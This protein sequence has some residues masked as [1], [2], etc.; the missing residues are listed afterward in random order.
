MSFRCQPLARGETVELVMH[1][2]IGRGEV[3]SAAV[4]R[5]LMQFPN[6]RELRVYL[7]SPGGDAFGGQAI[8]AALNRHPARVRV[9]VD[10]LAASAA[11]LVAMAGDDIRMA[12]GAMLM[13]HDPWTIAAGSAA[14]MRQIAEDLDRV[15]LSMRDIYAA[16]SG[17]DKDEIEEWM[18][19]E[20]WF[21]AAEA[22]S[23]G[24]ATQMLPAK[25]AAACV[26]PSD[27]RAMFRRL[28]SALAAPRHETSARPGPVVAEWEKR[29]A[30]TE[31]R[32][33]AEKARRIAGK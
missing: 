32:I 29:L 23:A 28:P 21:T 20:T 5:A 12:E 15:R 7:N 9:E 11:S 8:Y 33:A 2:A 14:T 27:M 24:L 17:K 25:R 22:M 1:G 4:V 6:A 10:G 26:I 19:A 3:E 18:S 16:R 31:A 13:I 30:Q